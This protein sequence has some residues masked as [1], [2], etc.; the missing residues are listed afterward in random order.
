MPDGD[1]RARLETQLRALGHELNAQVDDRDLTAAV[2][3]RL[4]ASSSRSS[5]RPSLPRRSRGRGARPRLVVALVTVGAVLA[6]VVPVRAAIRSF[7]DV[8]AVRVH[9]PGTRRAPAVATTAL[10]LGSRTTLAKAR[11]RMAV[12]VPTAPGF[13]RPDEVWFAGVG[14]GQVS[15]VY[16]A[17]P[18]L[19]RAAPTDVGLLIQEFIG[20][21]SPV[22]HKHLTTSTGVRPVTIGTEEGVFL[23]GNEHFLFYVDPTGAQQI[24]R[25][26][27]VGQALIFRRGPQT[28]RIEGSLPLEPMLAIAKSL[29]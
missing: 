28:I 16:R 18:G 7:F 14:G 6:L 13:G 10:T 5:A 20:D 17:R 12:A 4:T 8:G 11:Q 24:E 26:R 27:L 15:L 25:G 9:A 19:P 23:S 2:T 22:I 29:R 21:G 1:V 3:H